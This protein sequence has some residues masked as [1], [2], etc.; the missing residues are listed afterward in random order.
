MALSLK[1]NNRNRQKKS[2]LVLLRPPYNEWIDRALFNKQEGYINEELFNVLVEMALW[3]REWDKKIRYER[4]KRFLD[5][6]LSLILILVF[7]PVLLLCAIAIKLESK[8][9]IFFRQLRSGKFGQ[10]F[11]ILKFRTMPTTSSL[12]L[13]FLKPLEKPIDNACTTKV[14]YFLRKHKLDELPQLWNC[15]MGDMSIVGPRP[16]S[17]ND[18]C[19]TGK[20]YFA[21]FAVKPGMTG[22]WQAT[23]SNDVDARKKLML[24]TVY[25]RCRCFSLDFYLILRTVQVVLKGESY[26]K[27]KK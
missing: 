6:S 1:I 23:V 7:S 3:K 12:S 18:T 21:R 24:D 22:L 5:I 11:W 14:G 10:P 17:M 20:K 26:L 19:T 9:P 4:M 2:R 8:G 25:V 16:L 13:K 27:K 15:L